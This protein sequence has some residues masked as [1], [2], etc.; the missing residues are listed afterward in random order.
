M[1]PVEL[2][3]FT[4]SHGGIISFALVL[5]SEILRTPLSGTQVKEAAAETILPATLFNPEKIAIKHFHRELRKLL[6]HYCASLQKNCLHRA[7]M[8][9][10]TGMYKMKNI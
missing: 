2:Q 6:D 1:A 7:I 9:L 10:A 8:T 5:E 4:V 3:T